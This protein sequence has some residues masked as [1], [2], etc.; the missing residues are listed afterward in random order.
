[1]TPAVGDDSAR[2]ARS[3]NLRALLVQIQRFLVVGLLSF[4]VDYGLF[5]L[6]YDV[7]GWQYLIASST[8]FAIS[9]VLNYA[10]T[11]K[12]VFVSNPGAHVGLEFA[13]YL[14]LNVVALG[15][16]QLILWLS[17]DSIGLSPLAGKLIATAVVLVYNFISRK[18]LL[19]RMRPRRPRTAASTQPG[20]TEVGGNA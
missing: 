19:E 1:M 20:H 12:Y 4:S 16:N 14:G 11:R 17:V 3:D 2:S 6:F 8:S 18:L 9:L 10:L 5:V 15:L 13:L 7:L